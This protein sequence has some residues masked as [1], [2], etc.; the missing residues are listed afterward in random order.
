MRKKSFGLA[1]YESGFKG[2]YRHIGV[3]DEF[4]SHAGVD[5]LLEK[6]GLDAKSMAEMIENE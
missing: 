4:V 1:L 5:R 2:K 3:P 6:Y